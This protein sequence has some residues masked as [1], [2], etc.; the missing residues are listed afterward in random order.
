[1]GQLDAS[2]TTIFF[3]S[4]YRDLGLLARSVLEEG[5]VMDCF[6]EFWTQASHKQDKTHSSTTP[7]YVWLTPTREARTDL[8]IYD[9]DTLGEELADPFLR[10][11]CYYVVRTV[12]E[13][14]MWEATG[15]VQLSW[16][17][18]ICKTQQTMAW[19]SS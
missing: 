7:N 19:R 12:P 3:D 18:G 11:A 2:I 8:Y 16:H 4:D 10:H 5:K 13:D 6:K 1:M 17:G 15:L 14:E 9:F